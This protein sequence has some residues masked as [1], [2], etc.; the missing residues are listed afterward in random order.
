MIVLV[1]AV[2]PAAWAGGLW[3]YERWTPEVGTANAGVAAQTQDPSIAASNPAGMARLEAPEVML[4][5]Q[6][7]VT[8]V[9]WRSFDTSAWRSPPYRVARRRGRSNPGIVLV[10]AVVATI[11][12]HGAVLSQEPGTYADGS[13]HLRC[14]EPIKEATH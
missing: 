12:L 14:P 6:P 3:L 10:T 8:D 11:G 2:S 7:V 1:Q 13:A 5:L 4:T 9:T